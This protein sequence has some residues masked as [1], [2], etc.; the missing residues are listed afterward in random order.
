[1]H[2]YLFCIYCALLLL[3]AGLLTA[4]ANPQ[5]PQA[6]AHALPMLLLEGPVIKEVGAS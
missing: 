2:P 5:E 3:A 1:M 6:D 4:T